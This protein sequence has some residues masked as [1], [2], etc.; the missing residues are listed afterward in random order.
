M[1]DESL[2][3]ISGVIL[4]KIDEYQNAMRKKKK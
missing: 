3:N 2:K 4:D 1:V